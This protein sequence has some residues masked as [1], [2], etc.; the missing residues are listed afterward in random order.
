MIQKAD[1]E[2]HLRSVL[3]GDV[4]LEDFEDWLD[5]ASWNM[6]ADS[7]PA[8][9]AAAESAL[10]ALSEM[11]LAYRSEQSARAELEII[12]GAIVN[13]IL[14]SSPVDVSDEISNRIMR[15]YPRLANSQPWIRPLLRLVAA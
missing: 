6:H 12:L 2:A 7:D 10:L 11:A 14:V 1:I 13:K 3:S 8:A 5:D 15:A 9:I 4:S